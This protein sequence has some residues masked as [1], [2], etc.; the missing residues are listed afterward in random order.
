MRELANGRGARLLV[1]GTG[2]ATAFLALPAFPP[3]YGWGLVSLVIVVALDAALIARTGALA[4]LPDNRLDERLIGARDHAYRLAFRLIGVALLLLVL[5]QFPAV[6]ILGSSG[7]PSQRDTLWDGVSPPVAFALLQTLVILPTM[8]LAWR[9][10]VE[11]RKERSRRELG[12]AL[13]APILAAG[14]VAIAWSGLVSAAVPRV[15]HS[16]AVP[17]PEM[18]VAGTTCA[19]IISIHDAGFGL[20]GVVRFR[21]EVC[22]N[23]RVA[24]V[25]GAGALVP[26]P[27]GA[28][29]D[30]TSI[31]LPDLMSCGPDLDRQDFVRISDAKCSAVVDSSGTLHYRASG[32]VFPTPL[33]IGGRDLLMELVVRADGHI[34]SFR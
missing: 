33:D 31:A 11:A 30:L 34:V 27:A 15:A 19:H 20:A 28:P 3:L 22:W 2:G 32:H 17:D 4:F 23:G 10:H 16:V 9:G 24:F 12:V 21:D 25:F 13:L 5:S 1:L 29:P 14:L 7:G 6:Y 26:I 8:V 18:S